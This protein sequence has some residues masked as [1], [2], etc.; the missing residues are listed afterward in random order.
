MR[1]IFN[2]I[3]FG[4]LFYLIS[5][6]FP[7]A[8]HTLVGWVANIYEFISNLVMAGIAKLNLGQ[9]PVSNPEPAKAL[10]IATFGH[11]F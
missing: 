1:F 5:L 9:H 2:F 3:F 8:F 10:L 6:F 11:R 4:L 7:E